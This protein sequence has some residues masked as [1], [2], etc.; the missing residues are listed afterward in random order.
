M[1]VA[2]A[3]AGVVGPDAERVPALGL[4]HHRHNVIPQGV[5]PQPSALNHAQNEPLVQD[6]DWVLVTSPI[7]NAVRVVTSGVATLGQVQ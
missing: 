5:K 3:V 6:A 7:G 1:V 2:L 4:G